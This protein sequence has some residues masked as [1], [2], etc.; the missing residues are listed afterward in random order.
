M[1][2]LLSGGQPVSGLLEAFN[3]YEILLQ[4]AKGPMLIFKHAIAVIE[5]QEQEKQ[6]WSMVE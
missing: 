4:T 1:I 2:R 3:A 6:N 5:I